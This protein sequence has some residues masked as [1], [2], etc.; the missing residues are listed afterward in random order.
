MFQYWQFEKNIFYIQQFGAIF[1][2]SF[3]FSV[4]NFR[5]LTSAYGTHAIESFSAGCKMVKDLK[6]TQTVDARNN[7][8]PLH[9]EMSLEP[10]KPNVF[11]PVKV[12]QKRMAKA[13][14]C[15]GNELVRKFPSR[16]LRAFSRRKLCY[17][18]A[19]PPELL[20]YWLKKDD[21]TD[22]DLNNPP[23]DYPFKFSKH[24]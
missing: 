6:N 14:F 1:F 17:S 4:D 19:G 24:G 12:T 7:P 8:F 18:L 3:D 11:L 20:K 22:D 10:W 2:R 23:E 9:P 16:F 21:Y 13:F 15:D 5:E